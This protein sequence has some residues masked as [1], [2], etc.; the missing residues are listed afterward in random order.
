MIYIQTQNDNASI[1]SKDCQHLQQATQ[2]YYKIPKALRTNVRKP[3]WIG[4]NVSLDGISRILSYYK[5]SEIKHCTTQCSCIDL[6]ND[7]EFR[8][9]PDHVDLLTQLKEMRKET[10]H[11]LKQDLSEVYQDETYVQT[12]ISQFTKSIE[13]GEETYYTGDCIE[14]EP[15]VYTYIINGEEVDFGL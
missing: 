15:P 14:T 10:V 7:D 9:N 4:Y 2:D 11:Q 5:T 12:I 8:A 13:R 6:E 1:L 3:E